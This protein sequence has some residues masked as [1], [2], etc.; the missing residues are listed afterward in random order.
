[1]VEFIY[2]ISILTGPALLIDIPRDKN[3]TGIAQFVPSYMYFVFLCL[4]LSS[5]EDLIDF[6][7]FQ[8]K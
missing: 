2:L 8:L 1:M 6:V 5:W 7:C 3:I 4:I